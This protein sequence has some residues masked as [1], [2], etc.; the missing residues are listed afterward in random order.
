[1]HL[2]VIFLSRWDQHSKPKTT[3]EDEPVGT[4]MSTGLATAGEV[5]RRSLNWTCNSLLLYEGCRKSIQLFI[6]KT[7]AL[8]GGFFSRHPLYD[9]SKIHLHSL[10]LSFFQYKTG[11]LWEIGTLPTHSY[12]EHQMVWCIWEPF[13]K[14]NSTAD[15]FSLWKHLPQCLVIIC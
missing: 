1:M 5:G 14:L 4:L 6:R 3:K 2:A 8:M 15:C 11:R 7:V 9:F 10:K 13:A 12:L